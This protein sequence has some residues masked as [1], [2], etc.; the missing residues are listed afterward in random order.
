[1]CQVFSFDLLT[2]QM[3]HISESDIYCTDIIP[4]GTPVPLSCRSGGIYTSALRQW[5]KYT[6]Q[7]TQLVSGARLVWSRGRLPTL[8]RTSGAQVSRSSGEDGGDVT[9]Y[10]VRRTKAFLVCF[11]PS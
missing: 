5:C 8:I 1:M 2:S 7:I 6:L 9:I 10:I 3:V 4:G 11:S